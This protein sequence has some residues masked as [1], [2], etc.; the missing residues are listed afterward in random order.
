MADNHVIYSEKP[1]AFWMLFEAN[2]TF[3]PKFHPFPLV[4]YG[5]LI[6]FFASP[7][8]AKRYWNFTFW[9]SRDWTSIYSENPCAFLMILD[10]ISA[11]EL[12]KHQFSIGL[13]R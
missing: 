11:L 12:K 10:A 13:T 2:F 7:E 3:R 9:K 5:I 8:I 1:N 6:D 4:L